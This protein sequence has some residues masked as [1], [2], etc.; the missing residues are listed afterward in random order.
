[1]QQGLIEI[2]RQLEQNQAEYKRL[3]AMRVQVTSEICQ[4]FRQKY[5]IVFVIAHVNQPQDIR[6]TFVRKEDAD[7]ELRLSFS[8]QEFIVYGRKS[9]NLVDF[10][11]VDLFE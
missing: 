9:A 11:L 4:G 7:A 3:M 1:M 2:N 5:P 6:G 10:Y 8:N